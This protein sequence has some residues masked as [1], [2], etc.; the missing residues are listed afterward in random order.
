[1]MNYNHLYEVMP[2]MEVLKHSIEGHLPQK[3]SFTERY[4]HSIRLI[5]D[6][7]EDEEL[8]E[9][10]ELLKKFYEANSL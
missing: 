10:Y 3:M 6:V 4:L 9:K 8:I 1:M 7:F 2:N 5:C